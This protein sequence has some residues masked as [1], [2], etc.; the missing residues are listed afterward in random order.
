[1][2]DTTTGVLFPACPHRDVLVGLTGVLDVSLVGW[3]VVV[4]ISWFP[5][6]GHAWG[7]WDNAGHRDHTSP[8]S[9]LPPLR[10]KGFCSKY[11]TQ[12]TGEHQA[13]GQPPAAPRSGGHEGRNWVDWDQPPAPR[14][15]SGSNGNLHKE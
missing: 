12:G 2:V 13:W 9:I 3:K 14:K 1:M 11:P 4:A 8:T 7:F 6:K 15:L 5:K 10:L